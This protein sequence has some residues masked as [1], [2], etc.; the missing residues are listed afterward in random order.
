MHKVACASRAFPRTCRG[1]DSGL[2][3]S[4]AGK[5]V[6]G[7]SRFS[8]ISSLSVRGPV[9]NASETVLVCEESLKSVILSTVWLSLVL[10][11][12]VFLGLR[13]RCKVRCLCCMKPV[14][15]GTEF[16]YVGESQYAV[17]RTCSVLCK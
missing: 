9:L 17:C 4:A 10:G 16:L 5:F 11:V 6:A 15:Q 3:C 7:R 2:P 13:V 1:A 12:S 8:V 14:A